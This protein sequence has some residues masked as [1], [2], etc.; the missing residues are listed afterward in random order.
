MNPSYG[1]VR[2]YDPELNRVRFFFLMGNGHDLPEL[3]EIIRMNNFFEGFRITVEFINSPAKNLFVC[4]THVDDFAEEW[5]DHPEHVLYRFR[6]RLEHF[7]ALYESL[8]SPFCL[9]YI[10]VYSKHP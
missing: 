8:I 9:V 2:S 3:F 7:L 10:Q 4:R 6:N 1:A 5:P